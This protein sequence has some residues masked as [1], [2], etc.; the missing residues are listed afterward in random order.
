[1]V[2]FASCKPADSLVLYLVFTAGLIEHF[3]KTRGFYGLDAVPVP[4]KCQSTRGNSR[5]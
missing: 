4:H 2:G 3:G 1:M 5:H